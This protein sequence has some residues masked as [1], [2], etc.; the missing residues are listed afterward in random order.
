MRRDEDYE[1]IH[2]QEE[3]MDDPNEF[4]PELQLSRQE[5]RW[6]A[7]GAL[8]GALVIGAVYMGILGLII[9]LMLKI[10]M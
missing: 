8:K 2:D 3:R 7:L 10:W 4:R 6:I 1:I 5:R 9:W